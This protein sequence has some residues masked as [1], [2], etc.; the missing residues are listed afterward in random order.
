M[1]PERRSRPDPLPE[2]VAQLELIRRT[3]PDLW[4]HLVG[5]IREAS[6]NAA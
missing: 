5:L 2:V 3:Q 1:P 4:R 6:K